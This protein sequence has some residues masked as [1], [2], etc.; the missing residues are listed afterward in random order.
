MAVDFI[1]NPLGIAELLVSPGLRH[2]LAEKAKEVVAAAQAAAPKKTGLG[3]KSIRYEFVDGEAASAM[4]IGWDT[5][6]FYLKFHEL[7]SRYLPARPFLV[8][9]LDKYL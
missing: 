6:H 7:G 8:P 5:D 9:A 3:A 2:D 4:R 1:I